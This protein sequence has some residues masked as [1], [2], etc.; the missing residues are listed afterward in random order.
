M[1]TCNGTEV[2]SKAQMDPHLYHIINLTTVCLTCVANILLSIPLLVA[3]SRS[4]SLLCK[5]RFLFL[6]HLLCCDNLQLVI[7]LAQAALLASHFA[8]SVTHCVVFW[9]TNQFLGMVAVLLRATLSVD[10]CVAIK[11]PLRYDM[12]LTPR[13]QR[14][15]V[16][17]IWAVSL[18]VSAVALC[19]VLSRVQVN[20]ALPL[21]IIYMMIPCLSDLQPVAIF[22]M[23]V[24]AMVLPVCF[25][26]ILGCF[27]LLCWDMQGQLCSQR[28]AGVTL[29]MQ[30]VQMLIYAVA[31]VLSSSFVPAEVHSEQL[32]LAINTIY[33]VGISLI[34]LVYGYR[35]RELQS[36]LLK[37]PVCSQVSTSQ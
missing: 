25:I 10:R 2:E 19:M 4:P 28:R 29:A 3:M 18:L 26:T 23:V 36:R 16:A 6:F 33:I 13:W 7:L 30:A 12:L 8:M 14:M 9:A 1:R 34:S 15:A 24:T 27:V 22:S 17:L 5:S 32:D 11:L 21:C 35:S 31:L 37:R 20:A